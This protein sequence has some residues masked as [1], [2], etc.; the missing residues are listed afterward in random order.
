MKIS[1]IWFP[2]R[3][4]LQGYT[5][6]FK[7]LVDGLDIFFE[8]DEEGCCGSELLYVKILSY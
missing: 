6:K 7:V 8:P 5:H 3:L 1:S 2:E 4:L